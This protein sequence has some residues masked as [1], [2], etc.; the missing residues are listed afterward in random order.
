M[1]HQSNR[2]QVKF[3]GCPLYSLSALPV[4]STRLSVEPPSP[5]EAPDVLLSLDTDTT[6]MTSVIPSAADAER[7]RF[8]PAESALAVVMVLLPCGCLS[9]VVNELRNDQSID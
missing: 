8:F 9:R 5:A 3:L 1:D 6:S 2:S 7:G 4:M